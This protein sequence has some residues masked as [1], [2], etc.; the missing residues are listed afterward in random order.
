[1]DFIDLVGGTQRTYSWL[2]FQRKMSSHKTQ[3][4]LTTYISSRRRRTLCIWRVL[5]PLGGEIT[6]TLIFKQQWLVIDV[7]E[8]TTLWKTPEECSGTKLFIPPHHILLV[9]KFHFFFASFMNCPFYTLH[10]VHF[11]LDYIIWLILV[12]QHLF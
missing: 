1:M 11:F 4:L 10:N 12:E 8:L 5:G 9:L 2:E 6:D 7:E 3:L